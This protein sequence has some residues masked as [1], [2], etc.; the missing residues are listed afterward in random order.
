MRILLSTGT[1]AWNAEAEYAAVLG[2]ELLAAGHRVWMW[3]RP[4]M[5]N[6]AALRGRGLPVSGEIPAGR[7]PF[8]W[9]RA[10]AKLKT[11]QASERIEIVDAFH[12]PEFPFHLLAAWGLPT[13]K[14]IRTR[15]IARPIRNNLLNRAMHRDWCDGI[16]TSSEA[17]RA[18]LDAGL[19]LETRNVRTIYYP[20]DLPPAESAPARRAGRKKLLSELE[21]SPER[22]LLGVVG[23]MALEK[24][25]ARLLAAMETVARENPKVLLVIFGKGEAHADRERPALEQQVRE[26]GLT[27]FVRF[28]GFRENLRREM[29]WLDMGVVPSLESEVNCRVAVEFFSVGTPVVAFPTGALPEV[30]EEGVSGLVTENHDAGELARA[31]LRLAGDGPLRA[32]L[33]AGARRQAEHRFSRKIF[34]EQTLEVFRRALG[35]RP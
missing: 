12:S 26:A 5:S 9:W 6:E 4:N 8:H 13:P 25:H 19:G 16:I 30:V 34:L 2:E 3:T 31:L 18:Q 15:G 1:N 23:R 22:L 29:G 28:L 32:K 17:V 10:F 11:L 21:V 33:G 24:G 35:D 14:V 27:P 7:N 20:V